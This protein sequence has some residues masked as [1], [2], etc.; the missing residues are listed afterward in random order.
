[1]EED[2]LK[3]LFVNFKPEL[4]SDFSFMTKLKHN[5]D[6]VELVKQHNSEVASKRKKAVVIAACVG[7][8]VG[9]LF[10]LT[11][12]YIGNMMQNLQSTLPSGS[13]LR[14]ITDNYLTLTLLI[15]AGTTALLS[16]NAYDLSL[17]LL[18]PK[19]TK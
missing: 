6:Q 7:F 8:I 13:T 10:S 3:D 14:M 9:L 15:M 16:L 5:L 19:S 2:K 4:P 12:P 18:T 11:L 1:M 17:S